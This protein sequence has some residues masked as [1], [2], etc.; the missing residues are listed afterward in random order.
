MDTGL[1]VAMNMQHGS[2]ISLHEYTGAVL[3][4]RVLGRML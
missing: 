3:H 2:I 4:T 1:H